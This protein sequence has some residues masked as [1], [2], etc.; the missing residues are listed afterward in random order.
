MN[1]FLFEVYLFVILVVIS[2]FLQFSNMLFM[3]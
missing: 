2:I 1:F 3:Y